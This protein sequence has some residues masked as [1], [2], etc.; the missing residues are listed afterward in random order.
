MKRITVDRVF[1]AVTSHL[2]ARAPMRH[3]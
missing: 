2:A 1:E 3:D